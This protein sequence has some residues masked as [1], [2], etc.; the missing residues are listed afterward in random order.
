MKLGELV[1]PRRR[2]RRRWKRCDGRTASK[3]ATRAASS[4]PWAATASKRRRSS[5]T[6]RRFSDEADL[7]LLQKNTK[8]ALFEPLVGTAAHAL[9]AVCD[10]V[11]FGTVSRIGRARMRWRSTRRCSRRTWRRRSIG[12]AS[13]VG[14]CGRMRRRREGRWSCARSRSGGPRSGDMSNRTRC[15]ARPDP[16][17]L[18]VAALV[19]LAIGDPA[20]AWHPVRLV[21]RVLTWIEDKLRGAGFDGYGG[22]IA[23]VR[24]VCRSR[25][26]PW[27][28]RSASPAAVSPTLGGAAP[29][30]CPLQPPCAR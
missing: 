16:Y 22:G 10:R 20:Y 14:G 6:S 18:G 8:A 21:G 17:L 9:A 1:G 12:G 19:D 3:P 5:T 29:R 23:A 25:R 7:E 4:T 2:D 24:R 11:R 28:P 26:S 13:S 27:L 15:G 30:I